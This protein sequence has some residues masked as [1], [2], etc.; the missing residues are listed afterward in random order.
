MSYEM[1]CLLLLI[2][3]T[4]HQSATVEVNL[5]GTDWTVESDL[6]DLTSQDLTDILKIL[7]PQYRKEVEQTKRILVNGTV[8]GY[9]LVDLH[10][11]GLIPDPLVK[12][13]DVTFRPL[14]RLTWV[15]RKSVLLPEDRGKDGLLV[16]EGLDT[17]ADVVVN[18]IHF[19]KS[20]YNQ[21]SSNSFSFS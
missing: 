9:V 15:Y 21:V 6:S 10:H 8:P 5:S 18:K 3:T 11:E 12:N 17:A 7:N 2:V 1:I 4:F 16:F 14:A 13:H 20:H 19:F